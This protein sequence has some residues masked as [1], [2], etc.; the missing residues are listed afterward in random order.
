MQVKI[1]IEVEV[2]E[3]DFED[4]RGVEVYMKKLLTYATAPMAV[5]WIDVKEVQCT[6]VQKL[7]LTLSWKGLDNDA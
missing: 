7:F 5:L 2:S 6:Q 1:E 4:V 3:K